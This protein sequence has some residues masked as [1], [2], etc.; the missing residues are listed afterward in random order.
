MVSVTLMTLLLTPG[1]VQV[2]LKVP[3]LTTVQ[4]KLRDDCIL[5]SSS[6]SLGDLNTIGTAEKGIGS[7]EIK[8][9]DHA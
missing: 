5:S 2:Q 9:H 6:V 7:I 3:L 1:P 4:D 8:S